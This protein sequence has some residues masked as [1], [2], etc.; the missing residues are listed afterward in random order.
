MKRSLRVYVD[1]SRG[2][3]QDSMGG[4][5]D[6]CSVVGCGYRPRVEIGVWM[7]NGMRVLFRAQRCDKTSGNGRLLPGR[8]SRI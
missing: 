4:Q 1:V 6:C 2:R 3:P 7:A 8:Q 5:S